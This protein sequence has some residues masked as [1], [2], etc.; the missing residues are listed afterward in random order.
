ML[1]V[2]CHVGTGA[3]TEIKDCPFGTG[4]HRNAPAKYIPHRAIGRQ[5]I[6]LNVVRGSS[7]IVVRRSSKQVSG[8]AGLRKNSA[9]MHS[10]GLHKTNR[11]G[12][13]D[14]HACIVGRYGTI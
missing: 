8:Q 13:R 4:E 9:V 6:N 7:A 5:A 3:A 10:Y 2:P 1:G 14:P 12:S 11:A